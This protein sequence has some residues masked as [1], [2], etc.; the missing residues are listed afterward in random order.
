M[1]LSFG[2][3]KK[4]V[5]MATSIRSV[6]KKDDVVH[7]RKMLVQHIKKMDD[8]L[9]SDAT[10]WAEVN[11]QLRLIQQSCADAVQM[12]SGISSQS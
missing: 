7:A 11:R 2:H 4:V 10:D 6:W 3:V 1:S 12:V 9:I 8:Q 5:D